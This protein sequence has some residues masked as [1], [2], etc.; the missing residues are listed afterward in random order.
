MTTKRD[1]INDAFAEIG[2]ASYTFDA[3]AEDLQLAIR[4]LD[5]MVALW[6][7]Q[8]IDIGYPIGT[9]LDDTL[10]TPADAT[11]AMV[12]GLAVRLAPGHGKA[13]APDTRFAAHSAY[14][15]ILRK[16]TTIPTLNVN[17]TQAPAGAGNRRR[18]SH[19]NNTLT[20]SQND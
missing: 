2:F 13:I 7:T 1:I 16:S 20:E 14:L 6:E 5:R 11:D 12:L 10:G 4:S 3:T 18:G 8:G 17:R 9:G 19:W 15:A